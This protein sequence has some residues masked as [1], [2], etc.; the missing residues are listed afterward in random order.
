MNGCYRVSDT[1]IEAL[2]R[3]CA[4]SLQEFEFSCNQ[5]ITS[6]SIQYVGELQHLR[7]LS[8]S[9]CPQLDDKALQALLNMQKLRK[10][11]LNQMER[12]SDAFVGELTGKLPELEELSL[13]RCAQ[14]SDVGVRAA[15]ENCRKL[16]VLDLSDL[17]ELTDDSFEPVRGLSTTLCP[18]R[19]DNECSYCNALCRSTALAMHCAS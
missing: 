13:A 17:H 8:L 10:L 2:V 4:P 15:L 3:R 16:R 9:E 1:G 18:S 5:R 12:I 19:L 11:E 7:A 6:A 14:L